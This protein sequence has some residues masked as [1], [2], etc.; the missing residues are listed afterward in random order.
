MPRPPRNTK[1]PKT[2][3]S[4]LQS[5]SLSDLPDTQ[6][7]RSQS[8]KVKSASAISAEPAVKTATKSKSKQKK[9]KADS[10]EEEDDS[11]GE[12]PSQKKSRKKV[13]SDMLPLAPRA[14]GMK[15]LVG[16][17]VSV[18]KG[19]EKASTSAMGE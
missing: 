18:A 6:T 2:I 14:M 5:P 7:P 3:P 17:H 13:A 15:M 9:R 10:E 16:A 4:D 11:G 8:I 19:L 12:L 1:K